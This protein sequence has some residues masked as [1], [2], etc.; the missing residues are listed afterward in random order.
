[1]PIRRW[2]CDVVSLRQ[3]DF[4]LVALPFR[5]VVTLEV[6]A[7]EPRLRPH[8]AVGPRIEIRAPVEHVDADRVFLQALLRA[9]Q[10]SGDHVFEETGAIAG[11][12]ELAALE[13][14]RQVRQHLGAVR[15][16]RPAG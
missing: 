9:V 8:D 10:R 2:T 13:D 7:D 11:R 6:L 5:G 1:V 3:H 12:A 16:L 4:E 14:A 15:R